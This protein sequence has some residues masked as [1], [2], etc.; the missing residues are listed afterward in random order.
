MSTPNHPIFHAMTR[1]LFHGTLASAAMLAW[2]YLLGSPLWMLAL[3]C[4]I[5]A[6]LA[7]FT[8]VAAVA[9]YGHTVTVRAIH[10]WKT[11]NENTT[12]E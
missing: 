9:H 10:D 6:L 2:L 8:L 7:S 12:A 4:I 3:S 1:D 11:R 5:T